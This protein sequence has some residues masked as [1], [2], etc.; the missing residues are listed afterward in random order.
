MQAR[1]YLPIQG[2][3]LPVTYAFFPWWNIPND[4]NMQTSKAINHIDQKKIPPWR[5]FFL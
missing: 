4:L 3:G 5:D 2:P 1:F